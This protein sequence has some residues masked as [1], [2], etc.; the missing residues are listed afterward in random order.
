[1]Y[2]SYI[3]SK[4]L[5]C[6]FK[7]N[8]KIIETYFLFLQRNA[9]CYKEKSYLYQIYHCLKVKPSFHEKLFQKEKNELLLWIYARWLSSHLWFNGHWKSLVA[10]LNWN[11]CFKKFYVKYKVLKYF[12]HHDVTVGQLSCRISRK[13]WQVWIEFFHADI[14][15]RQKKTVACS[16]I[17]RH[18]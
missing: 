7:I 3:F 1:M 14:H 5:S 6:I 11:A 16:D 13:N 18:A 15:L 4:V 10:G 17:F 9:K 2:C 12:L 8:T